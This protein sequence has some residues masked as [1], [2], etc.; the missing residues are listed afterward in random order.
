M[1]EH[2]LVLNQ[3]FAFAVSVP[4]DDMNTLKRYNGQQKGA[5]CLATLLQ[6]D[7]KSDVARFTNYDSTCL[8]KTGMRQGQVS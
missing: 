5:T 2:F 1:K 8:A 4:H 6:N 7:L 3:H